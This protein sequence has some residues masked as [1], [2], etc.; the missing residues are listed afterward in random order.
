MRAHRR[1]YGCR[2]LKTLSILI[3][4]A[5]KKCLF[6]LP[7][8]DITSST[9]INFFVKEFYNKALVDPTIGYFFTKITTINLE[10]HLPHI[11]K[12]WEQQLFRTGDYKKNV[13]QI[14]KDLNHKETLQ[15]HHFDTW[16]SLFNTTIDNHFKGPNAE[17]L[18]TKALSIL[19]VMQLKIYKSTNEPSS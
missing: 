7:M 11:V 9:D 5:S 3:K 14:H 12:F 13:L 1:I 2:S 19:T 10:E 17:T 6:F 8:K 18:K 15:K 4:G 16:I